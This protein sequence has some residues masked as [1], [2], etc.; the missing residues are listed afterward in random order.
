MPYLPPVQYIYRGMYKDWWLSVVV[1]NARLEH[2]W[3]KLQI[4][5]ALGLIPFDCRFFPISDQNMFYTL[6]AAMSHAAALMLIRIACRCSLSEYHTGS[7]M[8]GV[9]TCS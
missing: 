5:G 6:L 3:L 9:Y 7:G 4:E 2:W 1:T 8:C